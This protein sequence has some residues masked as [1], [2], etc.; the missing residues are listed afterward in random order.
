[1]PFRIGGMYS[2]L[3]TDA[4]VK[5]MTAAYS[6]KRDSIQKQQT[7]L[8]WKQEK[9]K[10]MNSDI[11]NFYSATLS[12]IRFDN[13]NS[14]NI[15]YSND[16]SISISN[17]NKNNTGTY[18]LEV[19]S[20]AQS[21]FLTGK[22]LNKE[23]TK[24][25]KISGILKHPIAGSTISINNTTIEITEDMTVGQLA[26]E[27]AKV[28]NVYANYDD[29][30]NRFFINSTKSGSEYDF[31]IAGDDEILD[32]LGLAN[33]GESRVK[34]KDARLKFNGVTYTSNSNN[35][36]INGIGIEAKT[37]STEPINITISP[38]ATSSDHIRNFIKSYNELLETMQ[39]S[40]NKPSAKTYMPLTDKEKEAMSDNEIE[41]WEDA[42][43]ENSLSKDSSLGEVINL[44]KTVA[45]KSYDIN[46]KKISL[47]SIGI[48]TGSYFTTEENKRGLLEINENKFQK[49]FSED[50]DMVNKLIKEV[51]AD[52]Y[53]KLG[54]NSKSSSLRSVY[55]FYNDKELIKQE[56]EYKKKLDEWDDKISKM[57]DKY[58]KQFS[59]METALA[60]M[61]SRSDALANM[62]GF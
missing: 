21:G 1:M 37:I 60:K 52:L 58:Y 11:Y 48:T 59:L 41:K 55:K 61:Q 38:N 51:G 30:N 26:E 56:E 50:P 9:W 39:T 17:P 43:K 25:T 29:K 62:F 3:D 22:Q 54:Q 19:D 27:I 10:K 31:E 45:T 57:E 12:S 32:A 28:S 16:K 46:G 4:L 36:N 14:Y 2:G 13:S 23:I 35:F 53:N 47:A 15:T 7:A 24:D 42:G 33:D 34:G 6:T 40:Y 44:F 5:E 20:L 18:T 49:A 8:E